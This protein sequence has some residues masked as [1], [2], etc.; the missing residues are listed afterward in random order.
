METIVIAEYIKHSSMWFLMHEEEQE[1]YQQ[2]F[3][4]AR[5]PCDL[6]QG[7]VWPVEYT[8]YRKGSVT[9]RID[10]PNEPTLGHQA[11]GPVCVVPCG[12][13][14]SSVIP[15]ICSLVFGSLYV[16]LPDNEMKQ[17]KR[18]GGSVEGWGE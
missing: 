8:V 12:S 9:T 4:A 13:S 17:H 15:V 11:A 1:G 3:V 18:Y 5:I 10:P 7:Y 2:H 16:G 14:D 6:T